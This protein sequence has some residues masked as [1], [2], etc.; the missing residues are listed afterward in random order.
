MEKLYTVLEVANILKVSV[1]TVRYW[2]KLKKINY[3]KVGKSVRIK[4]IEIDRL[5][6]S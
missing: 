2:I 4:Q 5:L 3:I 6:G 1:A